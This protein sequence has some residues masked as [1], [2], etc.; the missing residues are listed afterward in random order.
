[1]KQISGV[2]AATGGDCCVDFD[3]ATCASLNAVL[4]ARHFG[5]HFLATKMRKNHKKITDIHF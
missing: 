5:K 2:A 1:M 3:L 4:T